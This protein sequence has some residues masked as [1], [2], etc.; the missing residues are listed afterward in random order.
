MRVRPVAGLWFS[1]LQGAKA[2]AVHCLGLGQGSNADIVQ[3]IAPF[4]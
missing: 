2:E 1:S 3:V 4:V